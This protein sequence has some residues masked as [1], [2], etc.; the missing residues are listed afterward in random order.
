M[1]PSP[2]QVTCFSVI[3]HRSIYPSPITTVPLLI[4]S[5]NKQAL[6]CFSGRQQGTKIDARGLFVLMGHSAVTRRPPVQSLIDNRWRRPSDLPYRLWIHSVAPPVFSGN[7]SLSSHVFPPRDI[8]TRCQSGFHND[9]VHMAIENTRWHADCFRFG[10]PL[11]LRERLLGVPSVLAPSWARSTTSS[12]VVSTVNTTSRCSTRPSV[13]SVVSGSPPLQFPHPAEFIVGV[14]KK[15]LNKNYHAHCFLCSNCKAYLEEGVWNDAGRIICK[16]CKD[17][18]PKEPQY[19]CSQCE[20][21]YWEK[22]NE[23]V[24]GKQAIAQ[25]DLLRRG[26]D[27]FHACHFDCTDCK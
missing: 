11:V 22:W 15:A 8:C 17:K 24:W 5:T 21:L 18:I 26:H 16:E 1:T 14:V 10:R 9:E 20:L 7:S 2:S 3:T 13:P 6:Y 27:F 25:E 12:R 23:A 4:L 19:I